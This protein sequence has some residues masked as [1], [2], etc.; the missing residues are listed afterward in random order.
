MEEV[1]R[2]APER[3]R[4]ARSRLEA[5]FERIKLG[6]QSLNGL[7]LLE[8]LFVERLHLGEGPADGQ[9]AG[10]RSMAGNRAVPE[11][12]FAP[13]RNAQWRQLE[14]LGSRSL[15]TPSVF[16]IIAVNK[17][18]NLGFFLQGVALASQGTRGA[19]RF[20]VHCMWFIALAAEVWQG[21]C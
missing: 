21:P 19:F 10:Y 6:L 15:A 18:E 2:P 12:L 14:F 3:G 4:L 1:G 17:V 5:G 7:F 20:P 16:R 8:D 11:C 13:R 9:A